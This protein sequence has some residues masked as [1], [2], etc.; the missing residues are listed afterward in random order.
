M[1][2]KKGVGVR[3]DPSH[4]TI[5]EWKQVV[6]AC[7]TPGAHQLCPTAGFIFAINV[8]G[9]AT[10]PGVASLYDGHTATGRHVWEEQ[11]LGAHSHGLV[12]EV[13][14]YCDRGIH[15]VVGAACDYVS[16]QWLPW[17]P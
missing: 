7:F 17:N 1:D 12:F 8:V 15:L 11:S 10:G 2:E 14:I 5:R 6:S 9:E 16:V 13:P 3:V 4:W